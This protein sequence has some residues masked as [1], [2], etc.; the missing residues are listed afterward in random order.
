[1]NGTVS[2]LERKLISRLELPVQWS[3]TGLS[4]QGT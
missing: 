4:V 2:V 1:M 3:M